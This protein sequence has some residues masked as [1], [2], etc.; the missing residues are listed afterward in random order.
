MKI[1]TE[2]TFPGELKDEPIICS[3][4]K[5][6]NITLSIIE[7]SF[8]TEL[9]WALL[10]LEGEEGELKNT[11]EYIKGKGVKIEGAQEIH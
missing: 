7:A 3:I 10:I 4:C 5:Q 2:W 11:F 6:F 9:G 8:S 1:K